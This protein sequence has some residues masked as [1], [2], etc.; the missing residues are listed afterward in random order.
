MAWQFILRGAGHFSSASKP[1]ST[2]AYLLT[3]NQSCDT[4]NLT[5]TANIA[6]N[7]N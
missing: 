5:S 2:Y 1:T 7:I 3:R 4:P 6:N